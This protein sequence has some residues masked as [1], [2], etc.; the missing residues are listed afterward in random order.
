MDIEAFGRAIG[1]RSRVAILMALMGG[2]AL[3]A[4]ELAYRARISGQ[5][6]SSHL[7]IL[8]ALKMVRVRP[9]GRHRYVELADS[10][11]AE[12]IKDLA[13]RLQ[14]DLRDQNRI[15]APMR[16]ARYCYDHLAG[17]LGVAITTAL[18]R[19]GVLIAGEEGFAIGQA[20]HP[21]LADLGIDI[22]ALRAGRRRLAP[23]CLDW[24]ERLP[25]VAGAFGAAIASALESRGAIR[26]SPDDR[27]VAISP[28]GVALLQGRFG[29]DPAEILPA[30]ILPAEI[31]PVG[32]A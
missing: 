25:H 1:H 8:E 6:V 26:R 27:S 21:I 9:C 31:L 29:I 17:R 11:L 14:V 24:S 2:K 3:P 30:E 5:T 10:T 7:A 18:V 28:A 16:G 32:S 22:A 23:R 4:G 15:A 19:E 13:S 20:A 12:A